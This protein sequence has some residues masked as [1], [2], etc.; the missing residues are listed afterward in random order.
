[1]TYL[2]RTNENCRLNSVKCAKEDI[3]AGRCD[4][5]EILLPNFVNFGFNVPPEKK[6]LFTIENNKTV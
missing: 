1:M 5:F 6:M 2:H 3:A 4:T